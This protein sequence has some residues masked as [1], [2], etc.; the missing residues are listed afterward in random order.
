MKSE[1]REQERRSDGNRGL[2]VCGRRNHWN[3]VSGI[4]L[5]HEGRREEMAEAQHPHK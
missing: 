5:G 3:G 2:W 1:R 4:A